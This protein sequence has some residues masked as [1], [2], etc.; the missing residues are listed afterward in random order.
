MKDYFAHPSIEIWPR[1][2]SFGW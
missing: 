1:K 2:N